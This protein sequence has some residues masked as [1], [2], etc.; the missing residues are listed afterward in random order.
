MKTL[1]A[2]TGAAL[3]A[4][5]FAPADGHAGSYAPVA[6]G[7]WAPAGAAGERAESER[8]RRAKDLMSDDRWVAAI[9]VLRAAAEDPAEKDRDEALFW[10]AHSQNRA[11]DLA[12]S[13]ESIR[14]LQREHPKS[15]WTAPAYSLLIELAQKL[16]RDDVLWSTAVPPAPPAPPAPWPEPPRT[17]RPPRPSAVAPPPPPPVTPRVAPA[18]P[19]PPPPSAWFPEEYFPD[20][21]LRVE[22]LGRLIHLDPPRVIPLLRDIALEDASPAAAR[23]AIFVLAQSR[24]PDAHV[25]VVDVART[26]PP[27][28]RLAAVRELARFGG[29][30]ASDALLQ[31]YATADL[32]VKQQV[33]MALGDRADAAALMKIAQT[34]ADRAIRENAIVALGRAGG[35]DQLRTMYAKAPVRMRHAIIRGLFNARDEDGLIMIAERERNA[36]VRAEAVT[37][38]RLLGT[39]GARAWLEKN[40]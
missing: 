2:V 5:L 20:A 19:V 33:V 8:L 23:R 34:E 6:A 31:V 25:T 35:R 15:R 24:N 37:R 32:P 14:R 1:S 18:Q 26:G 30:R 22:A 29:E 11:G 13:V 36:R 21:T 10:L 17:A 38:L 12:E 7:E 40:R 39:P 28:V 9:P 16:G 27:Q 3:A 4:L